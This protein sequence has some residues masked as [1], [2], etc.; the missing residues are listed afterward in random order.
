MLLALLLMTGCTSSP[1]NKA[2][3]VLN[4]SVRGEGIDL[5]DEEIAE[6]LETVKET[7]FVRG[8]REDSAVI[9][10]N[11][12]FNYRF[13]LDDVK[14]NIQGYGPVS[15]ELKI[16]D[17]SRYYSPDPYGKLFNLIADHLRKY[18]PEK[19]EQFYSEYYDEVKAF[20]PYYVCYSA[21]EQGKEVDWGVVAAVEQTPM[22]EIF[23]FMEVDQESD[24]TVE[25]YFKENS[26]GKYDLND[27]VEVNG[28]K[29]KIV[30]NASQGT[31]FFIVK[32]GDRSYSIHDIV[33][34]E[35]KEE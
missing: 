5:T 16:D 26:D 23:I 2:T 12:L 4:Y 29:I 3:K 17:S 34:P 8:Y 9:G 1:D 35:P 28:L 31:F 22:N 25:E 11:P 18:K 33:Y 32:S 20:S 7:E 6:F 24:L 10:L 30:G 27:E 21:E 13:T 14:Y 19:Y 15:S